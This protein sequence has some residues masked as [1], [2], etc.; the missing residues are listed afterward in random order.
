[1]SI[2]DK[3]LSPW[4][5]RGA[6]S[7]DFCKDRHRGRTEK[8]IS[9]NGFL[10]I[11]ERKPVSKQW[12][13]GHC[14]FRALGLPGRWFWCGNF[15]VFLSMWIPECPRW[16]S[17]F[18]L[19]L[20]DMELKID[21]GWSVKCFLPLVEPCV[22]DCQPAPQQ[23]DQEMFLVVCVFPRVGR[24][25]SGYVNFWC[26]PKVVAVAKRAFFSSWSVLKQG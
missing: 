18:P 4:K 12:K 26:F 23:I 19:Y 16:L 1:M 6:S 17:G 2:S 24:S 7:I 11:P 9:L 21:F 13:L 14:F 15:H 10:K 3:N 20:V 5:R 25:K 8:I 22:K